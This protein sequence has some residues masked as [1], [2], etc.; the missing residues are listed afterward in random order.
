M[1]KTILLFLIDYDLLSIEYSFFISSLNVT[2][3]MIGCGAATTFVFGLS[4][5]LLA[6]ILSGKTRKKYFWGYRKNLCARILN[7]FV[8]RLVEQCSK[9]FYSEIF[10]Q[11][12]FITFLLTISWLGVACLTFVP[13]YGLFY[14]YFVVCSKRYGTAGGSFVNSEYLQIESQLSFDVIALV[15]N[16][17]N[18]HAHPLEQKP[19][20]FK[21]AD[22]CHP[23]SFQKK[24]A[25]RINQFQPIFLRFDS[26]YT[27]E[28]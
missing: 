13:L 10:R 6:S 3:L 21:L 25:F 11:V 12:L 8:R 20:L 28:R 15:L 7:G 23:V 19:A 18:Q 27:T 16:E 14:V 9:R 5:V 24:K 2:R 1:V 17:I 26:V 22:I 4:S